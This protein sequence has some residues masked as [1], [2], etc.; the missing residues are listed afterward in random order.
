MAT[1]TAITTQ[2][3]SAP[4]RLRIE[5]DQQGVPT[6]F[7]VS[8]SVILGLRI[9]VLLDGLF[10]RLA[11]VRAAVER[12]AIPEMIDTRLDSSQITCGY[13]LNQS[14]FRSLSS[15]QSPKRTQ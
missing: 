14:S 1:Q 13:L 15:P 7:D 2:G 12:R 8:L 4:K 6:T 9:G 10:K 3:G 11:R 5:V